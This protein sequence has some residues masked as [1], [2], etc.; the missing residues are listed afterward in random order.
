MQ[1]DEPD[2]ICFLCRQAHGEHETVNKCLDYIK[3]SISSVHVDEIVRQVHDVLHATDGVNMSH[4]DIKTH[5]CDHMRTQ[6][7]VLHNTLKDLTQ[8][9]AVTKKCC[10][11]K[12]SVDAIDDGCT[13]QEQVDLRMLSAYLKIIDQ[14]VSVYRMSSMQD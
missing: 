1:I 7:I 14:V 3:D 5:I 6:K 4:E 10:V 9:A 2:N 11:S 13:A 8:L 12:P